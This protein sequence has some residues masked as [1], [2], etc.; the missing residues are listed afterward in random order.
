MAGVGGYQAP[1]HPAAVSGPG[2]L[3]QRTDGGAKFSF[4]DAPYGDGTELATQQAG[5]PMAHSAPRPNGGGAVP[6]GGGGPD[7]LGLDAPTAFPDEPVTSGVDAG[8]GPG[9][10]SLPVGAQITPP[11][12]ELTNLI[13]NLSASDRTGPLAALGMEAMR[14][15]L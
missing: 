1:A 4:P 9:S 10:E 11:N 12:G 3:S 14:R 15:G 5:A 8:P 7:I 13:Y 2:S 6:G